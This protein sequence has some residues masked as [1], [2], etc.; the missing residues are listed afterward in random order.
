MASLGTKE[1]IGPK[2]REEFAQAF[3][4][5]SAALDKAV[6]KLD[7]VDTADLKPITIPAVAV[8]RGPDS[9]VKDAPEEAADAPSNEVRVQQHQ[10]LIER[11]LTDEEIFDK[12][13]LF[14][15]SGTGPI[16]ISEPIA[17]KVF[18]GKYP[19]YGELLNA[20]RVLG[21]APQGAS[22]SILQMFSALGELQQAIFGW[23]FE[24]DPGIA[25]IRENPLDTSKWPKLREFHPLNNRD[26]RWGQIEFP[27]LWGQYLMWKG[28]VT[29]TDRELE[30]YYGLMT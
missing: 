12:C 22:K 29:P 8:G 21:D 5:M 28:W 3:Q 30:K 26:P 11:E 13:S 4:S 23:L 1:E 24:N 10:A 6:E 7:T 15:G 14:Y 27:E 18:V 9:P 2:Q 17:R 19:Y 16:F 20:E 25:R